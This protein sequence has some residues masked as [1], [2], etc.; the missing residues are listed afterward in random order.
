MYNCFSVVPQ[1]ISINQYMKNTRMRLYF[2]VIAIIHMQKKPFID[3]D[4]FIL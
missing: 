1:I 4:T 3:F 2:S